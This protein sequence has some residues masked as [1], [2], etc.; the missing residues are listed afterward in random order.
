MGKQLADYALTGKK[1]VK[2][3]SGVSEEKKQQMKEWYQLNKERVKLRVRRYVMKNGKKV[4]EWKEINQWGRTQ[5]EIFEVKGAKCFIC[6]IEEDLV[7]HHKDNKGTWERGKRLKRF[8]K[9][10]RLTNLEVLCGT[11]HRRLHTSQMWKEG[12]YGKKS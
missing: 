6:G 5:A 1:M 4:K 7:V 12:R 2:M 11:C 8:E 9:N 3:K 10:N